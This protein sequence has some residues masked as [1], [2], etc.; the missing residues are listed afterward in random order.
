VSRWLEEMKQVDG[1][2]DAPVVL[3]TLGDISIEPHSI[4]AI[5]QANMS[6]LATLKKR[7]AEL[8]P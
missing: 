7:V 3:S 4:E 6:A 8:T 5:K 1:H 2:D